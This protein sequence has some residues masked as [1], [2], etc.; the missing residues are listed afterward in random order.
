MINLQNY[1]INISIGK[2][3]ENN[4]LKQ[5]SVNYLGPSNYPKHYQFATKIYSRAQTITH[6]SIL[7]SL[8]LNCDD[9]YDACKPIENIRGHDIITAH[10]VNTGLS[11][12]LLIEIG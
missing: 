6:A 2:I 4:C 7:L 10:R 12:P 1:F 5:C 11:I 8:H 9:R 3:I